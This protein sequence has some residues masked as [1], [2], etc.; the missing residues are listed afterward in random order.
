MHT[1][2]AYSYR[3]NCVIQLIQ[4][5]TNLPLMQPLPRICV[6]CPADVIRKENGMF[7]FVNAADPVFQVR[8]ELARY[9]PE[10][11]ELQSTFSGRVQPVRC[12]P[13]PE[14]ILGDPPVN[15]TYFFGQAPPG[16][17]VYLTCPVRYCR[18]Q[19]KQLLPDG[20]GLFE[21]SNFSSAGTGRHLL[22]RGTEGH[23]A[24][25]QTML[26]NGY[27]PGR[28]F[29]SEQPLPAGMFQHETEILPVFC[30]R[31]DGAGR[32]FTA[33]EEAVDGTAILLS[34]TGAEQRKVPY[35]AN[36]RVIL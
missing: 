20:R 30:S 35:Q 26:A 13:V 5:H 10:T 9:L 14:S 36:R 27:A 4:E 29:C 11:V 34:E 19:L 12:S 1:E 24:L 31:A 25:V 7:A 32:F 16:T 22:L 2:T 21:S 23:C 28:F 17:K 3:L 8:I 18:I 33:A 15:T 6:S